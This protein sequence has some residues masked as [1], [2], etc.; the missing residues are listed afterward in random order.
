MGM[1]VFLGDSITDAGRKNSPNQLGN[2]YVNIF[3]E[4]LQNS[5]QHWNI[6]NRGNDGDITE[7]IAESLRNDCIAFHPDYVSILA[8]INN[9]EQIVNSDVS[10]QEKLYMLEDCIRAY[11][12][13]LFDLSRET[14]A[15]IVILEPFI[16]PC[17]G[18][19]EDWIPWQQKMSKN[20]NKL[21]RNYGAL[22]LP[23]QD[24]FNQK[25]EELGY[26]EITTDGIHLAPAGHKIL[27]GLVK[28]AFVL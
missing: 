12:E 1:I 28:E 16:F 8:G 17:D 22:F 9:L 5:N 18:L 10:E 4:A 27:A 23:L 24:T 11:H 2:G 20:I 15:K 6:I 26:R 25:I 14:L 3:A 7:K 21:A 19:Y 13:M